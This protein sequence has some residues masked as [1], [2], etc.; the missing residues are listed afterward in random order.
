MVVAVILAALTAA[1]LWYFF[2]WRE[3]NPDEFVVAT[4]TAFVQA[5]T[6][7]PAVVGIIDTT[8]GPVA[9]A[10]ETAPV[11]V[12]PTAATGPGAVTMAVALAATMASLLGLRRLRSARA[13]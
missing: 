4:P 5:E 10:P 2:V 8:P 6:P 11:Y 9:Q 12:D 1:G 7:V 3:A 13:L